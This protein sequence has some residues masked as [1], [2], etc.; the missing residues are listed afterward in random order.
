[1]QSPD[2]PVKASLNITI[3]LDITDPEAMRGYAVARAQTAEHIAMASANL[4]GALAISVDPLRIA[5]EV[6]GVRLLRGKVEPSEGH[7]TADLAIPDADG[8][9]T[10]REPADT[11]IGEDPVAALVEASDRVRG[12]SLE[13]L[14]YDGS[15]P[16]AER[17]LSRHRAQVLAGLLWHASAAMTDELF[18]DIDLLRG[19]VPTAAD[20]D[21]T[22]VIGNLPP[23]FANHYDAR[24]AARFLTV[25]TD[26]SMNLAAG[27][28]EPSCVAQELA[29]RCLLADA[30]FLAEELDLD[31]ELPPDWVAML[32]Q[33][34]LKF[35][36]SMMLFDPAMDGFEND[37]EAIPEGAPSMKFEDWFKP[38]SA[39]HHVPPFAER[40]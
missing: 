36:D 29:V 18:N 27:W 21:D 39:E 24:F 11:G 2:Q 5:D 1:M 32:E 9:A 25:C 22:Y 40:G 16:E 30:E 23:Q 7:A 14:G 26:L 12:L 19:R 31:A 13:R 10:G 34:F 35:A 3:D 17:Q 4:F 37:P 6:P 8:E 33:A 28:K 20:V 15:A 38:F